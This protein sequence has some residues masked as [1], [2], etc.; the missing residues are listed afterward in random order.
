MIE[1]N[2]DWKQVEQERQTITAERTRL[3]REE[4]LSDAGHIEELRAAGASEEYLRESSGIPP[5]EE[6]SL[7]KLIG[8]DYYQELLDASNEQDKKSEIKEDTTELETTVQPEAEPEEESS[9]K[10]LIGEDYYQELLEESLAREGVEPIDETTSTE[11]VAEQTPIAEQALVTEQEQEVTL[12]DP[13][14][15]DRIVSDKPSPVERHASSGSKALSNLSSENVTELLDVAESW[16]TRKEEGAPHKLKGRNKTLEELG[17]DLKKWPTEDLFLHL[18]HHES[19]VMGETDMAL[20]ALTIL[21]RAALIKGKDVPGYTFNV[22]GKGTGDIV[23]DVI[24]AANQYQPIGEGTLIRPRKPLTEQ[25]IQESR[26][27]LAL[28]MDPNRLRGKLKEKGFS[29]NDIDLLMDSTGF[30][31]EE[32]LKDP[33]QLVN[34][35]KSQEGKWNHVYNT[36]GNPNV[37]EDRWHKEARENISVLRKH[38]QSDTRIKEQGKEKLEELILNLETARVP[39]VGNNYGT[40]HMIKRID[41]TL[42]FAKGKLKSLF[43]E[44]KK[45]KK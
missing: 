11:T 16:V 29:D 42:E 13:L 24:L 3:N 26:D 39:L 20:A 45:A 25:Q 7:K 35:V 17:T 22:T 6:S 27:A 18:I 44:K 41:A 43:P 38:Y 33:S 1:E 30:A 32:V 28:A 4:G 5:E 8:E 36:A 21:N 31:V 9:L 14:S 10:K 12:G 2:K 40:S 15:I 34:N 37:K 19:S 23:K